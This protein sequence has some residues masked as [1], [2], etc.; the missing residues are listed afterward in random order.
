LFVINT[1]DFLQKSFGEPQSQVVETR[2]QV[3]SQTE[4]LPSVSILL[5]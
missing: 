5:S 4:P 1:I 3:Q 2:Q